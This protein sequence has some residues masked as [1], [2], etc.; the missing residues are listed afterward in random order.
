[1]QLGGAEVDE[2]VIWTAAMTHDFGAYPEYRKEGVDHVIRATVVVPEFLKEVGF[3]EEKLENV[4]EVIRGH[5]FYNTPNENLLE[6]LVF[7]DADVLDF[8]GYIGV[9]RLISIVGISDWAN[10]LPEAIDQIVKFSDELPG[11]IYTEQAKPLA[12][13][14]LAEMQTFLGGLRAQTEQLN[15][16]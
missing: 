12:E 10:T 2:E 5:M 3:P 9:A 8:M 14:R 6:A 13:E 7:H 16:L 11:K 4:I 15:R 1:M